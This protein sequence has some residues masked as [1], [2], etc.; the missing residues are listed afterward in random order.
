MMKRF[1]RELT[2]PLAFMILFLYIAIQDARDGDA[3]GALLSGI[4]AGL[5]IANF[6]VERFFPD[7]VDKADNRG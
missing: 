6:L 5:F 3:W 4:A 2:M 7:K 1:Y